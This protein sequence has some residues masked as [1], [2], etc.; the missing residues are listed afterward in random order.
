MNQGREEVRY[1]I[2]VWKNVDVVQKG[3]VLEDLPIAIK[4]FF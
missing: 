2:A 3:V 1:F 4:F